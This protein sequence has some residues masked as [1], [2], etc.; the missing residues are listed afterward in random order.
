MCWFSSKN[1]NLRNVKPISNSPGNCMKEWTCRRSLSMLIILI[2]SVLTVHGQINARFSSDK[3]SGCAPLVV[4]FLDES[5]GSPDSWRWDLGNGTISFLQNPATTYFTPGTYT[6]KL[7][8]RK[9]N[10]S[11]SLVKEKFITVFASPVVAFS[12]SDTSGCFPKTVYFNDFSSPGDGVITKWEW[13]FGDGSNAT[14]QHPHHV[15]ES[16]G[17]FNIS[18][19]VQNS[20]GCIRTLSREKYI[21]LNQ[22]VKADF[23]SAASTNCKPP[24]SIQFTNTSMG[25]GVLSYKWLFG[26]GSSS[27]DQNPVHLYTSEG[28]FRVT[29]ITKNATGCT[30]SFTGINPINIGN[31]KANFE[32]PDLT[33]AGI[34][35]PFSNNSTPPPVTSKWDFGDN[36]ISDS[37]HPV[38]IYNTPGTYKVKLV[39]NSGSCNDSL[40]KTIVVLP[41][42]TATFSASQTISCKSP[43]TTQ[44]HSDVPA[45]I[46]VTWYFGDG[47]SSSDL[48]PIH[49]YNREGEFDVT[50]M[51]R[52]NAGCVETIKKEKYIRVR[53][54]LVEITNL[55]QEGCIPFRFT[56]E[57]SVELPDSLTSY[58]WQWGDGTS[59]EAVK[60]QKQYEVPGTYDIKLIYTTATGCIDSISISQ[61]IR[62]GKNP[63]PEFSAAPPSGCAFRE[64]R[65]LDK[66]GGAPADRWLWR[67]GDGGFSD[68]QNPVHKYTDTG[69]FDVTLI[70]W[71][72]GCFDSIRITRFIQIKAPIA[73]FTDSTSCITPLK[74]WFTD[75]SVGATG[76]RWK[77]GDGTESRERNPAHIYV[78]GGS[79]EVSLTVTNDTCEHTVTRQIQIATEK[80]TFSAVNS[81]ACKGSLT[82]FVASGSPDIINYK[83]DFG[84]G[85]IEYGNPAPAHIY[86]RNG[87]YN[88]TLVT[89]DIYGCMDSIVR[90][91]YM[92]ISGPTA[93]FSA[94]STPVCTN[95][96]IRFEDSSYTDA[97]TGIK[98]WIWNYGD[99]ES[100][101]LTQGPFQ[102]LYKRGGNYTVSLTVKDETGCTNTNTQSALITISEPVASFISPDTLSCT[103]KAIRFVNESFGNA[104]SYRWNFHNISES[105]DQHPSIHF[106]EEGDYSVSLR[107]VDP[108]GCEDS[109]LRTHY[110]HIKDPKSL[111]TVSDSV[112]TCP[113][114]VVD[115]KNASSH[116]NKLEWDF[117]DGT[118]SNLAEPFHFYSYPGMYES[119][120]QVTGFGGCVSTMSK[121]ITV[122]GPQ[123]TFTYNKLSGCEPTEISFTGKTKDEASFIWD[124]NDGT[125]QNTDNSAITHSYT[126]GSY[127]PKMILVDPQGCQVPVQSPDTINIYGVTAEFAF[128]QNS[129]CD[130]G[131][132]HFIDK[133]TA[134]EPISSYEWK[135]GDG[136]FSTDESPVHQYD[137]Q[138]IFPVELLTKTSFGCSSIVK[139]DVSV[140]ISATPIT[141]I[142]GDTT[143]C[144]PATLRLHGLIVSKDT[145]GLF[146]NWDFGNS[147]KSTEQNPAV[148]YNQP[149]KYTVAMISKNVFGCA[150]TSYQIVE[151]FPLPTTEAGSDV[152]ICEGNSVELRASG[153]ETYQWSPDS[154]LSCGNCPSPIASPL[155]VTEYFVVGKNEYGCILKDSVLVNIQHPLQLL[156]S[157][158][159]TICMG[160]SAHLDASGVER[161]VWSPSADLNHTTI[162]SPVANPKQS[163]IY[164][165]IG[166]DKHQC[167]SDTAFIPVT[168]YPYPKV[169]AGPDRHISVG[170]SLHL[171]AVISPDVRKMVWKPPSGLNCATCPD[172]IATPKENTTYSI[173]VM[174]EGGCK[175]SDQITVSVF[176]S[177]SNLFLPNTFSPNSDGNNDVFHPRG[178]GIY[179]IKS[180]RVFNRWGEMI[181]EK[182]NMA[183]NDISQGWDG[184]HKSRPAPQDVYV[185]TVDVICENKVVLN[186]KGNVIL[187]R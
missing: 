75:L 5:E 82:Q 28:S 2:G 141:S 89:T 143:A 156:V 171:S 169:D 16:G 67:F 90:S 158:P 61:A 133:S 146:W 177:N 96:I 122:R 103:G 6:V 107:I 187:I 8:I 58:E 128:V 102:H 79:Y 119:K 140:T 22:G 66:T 123:G 106:I 30:D 125:L 59:S 46:Q 57:L 148:T 47:D 88:V 92:K 167:F 24:T 18:L 9:G 170:S 137:R 161:Y 142:T 80:V 163:T 175:T 155:L 97:M 94:S 118:K 21:R 55:K 151:A 135:F 154:D 113:P 126:R 150:D 1:S 110:I 95:S 139:Y 12:A 162:P 159:D 45:N 147:T 78:S 182:T 32:I 43:F 168:V 25:T 100:D 70:A 4:K 184:T 62:V 17:F 115:F 124:F 3:V 41:K 37:I 63:F 112:G 73:K 183:P 145:S 129:V 15:Y 23:I 33:C 10:G 86:S 51:V 13:D 83:W 87:E 72:S 38:K 60:P 149:G 85:I 50:L 81:I 152:T 71:N 77:F 20:N 165:V 65:F 185:Y 29:L 114:L 157:P 64:I 48:S 172:P 74:R 26:D 116:Y 121:I 120:L 39:A 174:N 144:T 40:D 111:Y 160:E 98:E 153:A 181:F 134:N 176:C 68:E 31:V 130:S 138:G 99:G 35:I 34:P 164:R 42:P 105:T 7:I 52:N 108:Y 173:E 136:N 179:S 36:T 53:A 27:V 56:P 54:P 109:I 132:I 91:A 44:F 186:F 76:W 127:V 178:K 166:S 49:S 131:V 11:D 69:F 93:N 117:G 104:L 19:R 14:V 180:F 101:T 84:D